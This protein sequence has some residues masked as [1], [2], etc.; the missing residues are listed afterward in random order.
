MVLNTTHDNWYQ[1][2]DPTIKHLSIFLGAKASG[3]EAL[4]NKFRA[5]EEQHTQGRG[6][7]AK[8]VEVDATKARIANLE[9]AISKVKPTIGEIS[10][11]SLEEDIS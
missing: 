5:L 1:S 6:N 9:Q 7:K 4:G 8:V 2:Q 3:I 11:D 10:I